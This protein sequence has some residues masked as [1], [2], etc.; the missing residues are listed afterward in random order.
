MI[1]GSIFPLRSPDSI[2]F[3]VGSTGIPENFG[4]TAYINGERVRSVNKEIALPEGGEIKIK[5]EANEKNF[6]KCFVNNSLEFSTQHHVN[7]RLL[8][9]VFL[10]AWGDGN[11]YRVEFNDIQYSIR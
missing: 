3:H 6:I 5:F 8:E 7:P 9:K 4:I 1:N 11:P 2:L 10:T